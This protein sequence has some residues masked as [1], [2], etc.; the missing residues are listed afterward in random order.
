MEYIRFRIGYGI[1]SD[2]AEYIGIGLDKLGKDRMHRN[3]NGKIRLGQNRL[4]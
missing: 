2:R 3:L 1:Y 4:E